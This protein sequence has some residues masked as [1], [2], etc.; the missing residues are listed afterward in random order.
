MEW[1]TCSR[2]VNM[3]RA[4]FYRACMIFVSLLSA[5][6]SVRLS[7]F[8]P[9]DPLLPQ[10]LSVEDK[11]RFEVRDIVVPENPN[12]PLES[13][14]KEKS[15]LPTKKKKKVAVQTFKW[16]QRNIEKRNPVWV[17]EKIHFDVSYLGVVAG[18]FSIEVLP[19]KQIDNRDV[20]H[21]QG[22]AQSSKLFSLFYRLNDTIQSYWDFHGLFSHRFRIVLD[23]SKQTRDAL[24][25]YD[26]QKKQT[27]YWNRWERKNKPKVDKREVAEMPIFPQ[28]SVSMLFY[29]RFV[30]LEVGK[31]VRQPVV[32]E[33][34]TWEAEVHVV[35]RETIKTGAGKF[36]TIVV[37]PKMKY[38]G[39]IKQ[40]G[41][42]Y[43]WL[44]DD[45]RRFPIRMHAEVKIGT[46]KAEAESIEM[47]DEHWTK[48]LLQ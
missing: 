34:K 12:P 1:G 32:S 29:M 9:E 16:P 19:M 43:I 41:N 8:D 18:K 2:G 45:E 38:H 22:R 47:G 42:S 6:S 17:G 3:N 10:E 40:K 39:V 5:C 46:I 24:E 31:V 13:Q 25:I 44:T 26:S 48:N 36:N 7:K 28:D 11:E 27:V 14:N 37:S 20:F 35:R 30:P 23:E 4:H 33:G 15:L 21:L